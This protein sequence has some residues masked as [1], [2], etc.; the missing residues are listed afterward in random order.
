[1]SVDQSGQEW[2]VIEE[3]SSKSDICR[4]N[5]LLS[6]TQFQSINQVSLEAALSQHLQVISAGKVGPTSL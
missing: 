5:V 6:K 3:M 1:M 2:A 4:E